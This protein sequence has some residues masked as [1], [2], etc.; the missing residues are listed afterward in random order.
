M[1]ISW[2]SIV[3]L[4]ASTGVAQAQ[5]RSALERASAT[6][7]ELSQADIDAMFD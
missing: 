6:Q 1:R 5:H 4:V 7:R 3:V 2:L